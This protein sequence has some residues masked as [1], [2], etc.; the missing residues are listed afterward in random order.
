MNN[1]KVNVVYIIF[2]AFLF[3]VNDITAE[4]I[5]S[6][7]SVGE[8]KNVAQMMKEVENSLLN[9]RIDSNSWVEEGPSSSGPWE[10]TPVCL[11]STSFFKNVSDS[12]ARLD[13]HKIVL[14]WKDG[15]APYL[16]QSYS[17]SFDGVQGRR[18][19]ISSSYNGKIYDR[20]RGQISPEKP[21][22]LH[23]SW[24]DKM[25]GVH[26]SLFFH[27]RNIPEPFPK[28]FSARF[29][30]AA[31]PNY[32]LLLVEAINPNYSGVKSEAN[33]KVVFEELGGIEYIKASSVGSSL[34]QQW[35]FDPN[36][37]FAL[38][39][40]EELRKDQSGNEHLKSSINVTKLEKQAEDIWWPVE[41]YFV[42]RPREKGKPWKRIVYRSSNIV[43]NDPNFDEGVFTI[44]FPAGY[45]INDKIQGKTYKVG[46]E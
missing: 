12:Q 20:Y 21:I 3:L 44:T 9:V 37:G 43:V 19:E 31:D 26:A 7:L 30:A 6:E 28:E 23:A 18:R 46:E 5:A 24:Y 27:Y 33:I 14:E 8:L 34:I 11:S 29:H 42:H 13:I 2:L 38:L 35:W 4:E 36:R 39:R 25:T 17:V 10:Q 40:F 15:A 41:A 32:Y 1:L 22:Q 45:T 16:E